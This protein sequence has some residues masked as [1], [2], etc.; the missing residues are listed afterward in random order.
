MTRYAACRP[1]RLK[2]LVGAFIMMWAQPA[3]EATA[4]N[5]VS[6]RSST[7][8]PLHRSVIESER[9]FRERDDTS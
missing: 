4:A 7:Q 9:G 3:V 2:V 5:G 8:S 1:A 6:W